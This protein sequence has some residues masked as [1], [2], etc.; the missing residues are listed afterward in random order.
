[1]HAFLL[2]QTQANPFCY[3]IRKYVNV[4]VHE[5]I[6]VFSCMHVYMYICMFVGCV[7]IHITKT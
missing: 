7:D 1:M 5:W 2:L 4:Y 6:D 3:H